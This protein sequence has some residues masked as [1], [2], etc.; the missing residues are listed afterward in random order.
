MRFRCVL[1]GSVILLIERSAT[2]DIISKST[3]QPHTVQ[4]VKSSGNG[5]GH[6][7]CADTQRVVLSRLHTLPPS[8]SALHSIRGA[9][10]RRDGRRDSKTVQT[11]P[12]HGGNVLAINV[13]VG[14]QT[15][16]VVLDTG[17]SDTWFAR[18]GFRCVDA[19][20]Q[21]I[22]QGECNFGAP[23]KGGFPLGP[24]QEQNFNNTYLSG[25][26]I[27]GTIGFENLTLGGFTVSKQ[28]IALID[29]A[30]W[31]GDGVTSGLMGLAY[32]SL[33]NAHH[34][35]DPSVDNVNATRAPY[36]PIFTSM[37]RQNLTS[38]VFSLALGR[39]DEESYLT[40]GDDLAVDV[41]SNSW[42]SAP[43]QMLE[44]L[45]FEATKNAFSFYTIL[46]DD[47]AYL[48]R[49]RWR[50]WGW[51]PLR[52]QIRR[53]EDAK[54][55]IVDS[56]TSLIYLPT[57]VADDVNRLFVPPA[58]FNDNHS[59]YVVACDATPPTL[60]IEISGKTFFVDGRDMVVRVQRGAES[61]N[62]LCLSAVQD[63]GDGPYI[64]GDAFLRNVVAVH[65]VGNA[66]MRFA[67][68]TY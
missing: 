40:F 2:A 20:H 19:L 31:N 66:E 12:L 47:I 62:E 21:S 67:I 36:D 22:D 35:D 56:G 29:N 53:R 46:V 60:G 54:P 23:F 37:W 43:L 27:T 55:M 14:P 44:L 5:D 65:D 3:D 26:F 17:S 64:L 48:P 15:Y 13:T 11:I 57:R 16:S 63:G 41:D 6:E 25:E 49:T 42:A 61:T 52:R 10:P 59:S 28:T 39:D 58:A 18:F 33:T 30:H 24:I 38:P 8:S 34:G 7:G 4:T 68:K 32:P 45:P 50:P 51:R 1:L 9:K